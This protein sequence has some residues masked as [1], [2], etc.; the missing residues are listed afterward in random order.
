MVN[1]KSEGMDIVIHN[2]DGSV[3]IKF[4]GPEV[5]NRTPMML[6]YCAGIWFILC[7]LSIALIFR[8]E[9]KSEVTEENVDLRVNP[10][11]NAEDPSEQP[12][13]IK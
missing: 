3:K 5:A 8:R 1:P 2:E 10:S 13:I 4:Y 9:Q 12:M 7:L 11:F 6:R